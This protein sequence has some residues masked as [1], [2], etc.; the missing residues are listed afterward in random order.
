MWNR[1]IVKA[2]VAASAM[3]LVGCG[4][5][6]RLIVQIEPHTV[7]M[8]SVTF[9]GS[10]VALARTGAYER[11]VQIPQGAESTEVKV[12][13]K[14]KGGVKVETKFR[15]SKKEPPKP[16]P[17]RMPAQ[18]LVQATPEAS[19]VTIDGVRYDRDQFSK[20]LDVPAGK[21]VVIRAEAGKVEAEARKVEAE[22]RCT[23]P[24]GKLERVPLK[25]AREASFTVPS[26]TVSFGQKI[27]F[28][29]SESGPTG[30]I[31]SYE[32]GFGDGRPARQSSEAV[33]T[34]TYAVAE[35]KS[36]EEKFTVTLRVKSGLDWSKPYPR[37]LTVRLQTE[38]L[39]FDVET[40]PRRSLQ[41]YIHPGESVQFRLIPRNP[42]AAELA[43]DLI[44]TFGDLDETGGESRQSLR[45]PSAQNEA[46]PII[47]RHAYAKPGRF[48][49]RLTYRSTLQ[50]DSDVQEAPLMRD[51]QPLTIMVASTPLTDDEL[52]ERALDDLFVQLMAFL[53]EAGAQDKR[54]AVTSFTS[55]NFEY[56]EKDHLPLIQGIT[57]RLVENDFYVLEKTPDVLARLVP[58][59]V[60]DVRPELGGT[61]PAD[62]PPA[63]VE[64]L[65]YAL[66]PWHP[67]SR[68][69][70]EQ[71]IR[72][73][74]AMSVTDARVTLFDTHVGRARDYEGELTRQRVDEQ[75]TPTDGRSASA[76]ESRA[77]SAED[78]ARRQREATM[79]QNQPLFVARFETASNLLSLKFVDPG[80]IQH[81]ENAHF[82]EPL[83][84]P[85]NERSAEIRI[86]VRLLERT[87]RIL[88][89]ADLIGRYSEPVPSSLMPQ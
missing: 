5:G 36:R 19:A 56:D 34:H 20:P 53:R 18:V 78:E 81:S 66:R 25:L 77:Q 68:D 40:Y 74:F 51:G 64:W 57:R 14:S 41:Q 39:V 24:A 73:G 88:R 26:T 2:L 23:V 63:Y 54:L 65:P 79:L 87:G 52:K 50:V 17:L 75:A 44:L 43:T 21:E 33:M 15:V 13:A 12:A 82:P 27:R 86:N 80:S 46:V 7:E 31:E 38:Q 42:T 11:V 89:A 72:Y 59:A 61:N 29:A 4:G 30:T 16:N 28:D 84:E 10:P 3:F 32:G 35:S 48:R 62:H 22:A 60:V 6:P 47:A 76:M 55:A 1:V 9:D 49:P 58:E 67:W 69:T 37:D 70:R 71:M 8:D 85:L 45:K 83:A